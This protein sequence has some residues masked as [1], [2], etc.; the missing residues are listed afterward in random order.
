MRCACIDIGS[1]TTR[2]LVAEPDPSRPGVLIEVAAHRAFVRLTA[3]ERRD[4]LP[5][6][7]V[8]AIAEAV[9]EQALVARASDIDGLRVVATAALRG[10]PGRDALLAHLSAA[11]GVDVEVLTGEDEARLAFAGATAPLAGIARTV[12]VADVGGGSTELAAGTPGR[13]PVWW[14]SLPIGSGALADAYLRSDPPGAG[15]LAAARAEAAAVIASAGCPAADV[16]WAVGGS[17]T[18]LRRLC[19]DELTAAALDDALLRLVD[20]PAVEAALHLD[21]HVE[22]VR[23][24]PAGL[25]L[26][27]EV[28]RAAACPLHVGSGGLREGVILDLLS[29]VGYT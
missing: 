22:R 15:E 28:A 24:L 14:A 26:L 6:D 27:A 2:L 16:A 4:G 1:N 7:K 21:L 9:A 29:Q 18:S 10:A 13:P 8:Q 11:A 12:V 25:V 17:A 23:L 20:R 19:G 5:P 3:A